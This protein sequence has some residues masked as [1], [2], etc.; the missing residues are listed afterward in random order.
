MKNLFL[1][2]SV[3]LLISCGE[4]FDPQME[5]A[6]LGQM[7]TAGELGDFDAKQASDIK[8]ICE[9]LQYKKDYLVNE[10][11]NSTNNRFTYSKRFQDCSGTQSNKTDNLRLNASLKFEPITGTLDSGTYFSDVLTH[12]DGVTEALCTS[13]ATGNSRESS[14]LNYRHYFTLTTTGCDSSSY[15]LVISKGRRAGTN[16]DGLEQYQI[17]EKTNIKISSK[18]VSNHPY[19]GVVL[20]RGKINTCSNGNTSLLEVE[21][22]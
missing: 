15:C 9:K 3:T 7:M 8:A 4:E 16:D 2:L 6:E 1:L 11:L 17:Y 21:L 18:G 5:G 22:R 20:Y 14:G 12:E 10:V 19:A 13:I